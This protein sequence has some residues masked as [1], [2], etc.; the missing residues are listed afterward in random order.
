MGGAVYDFFENKLS[1]AASV[2]NDLYFTGTDFKG[3]K[4]TAVGELSNLAL[5]LPI[6]TFFDLQNDPDAAN[7]ILAM[8][9]DMLGISTNTYGGK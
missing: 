2:V 3:D 4:P 8:M 6:K 9:A 5:P 7:I 1:P